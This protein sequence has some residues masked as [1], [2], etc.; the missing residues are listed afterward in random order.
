MMIE[1]LKKAGVGMFSGQLKHIEH[2]VQVCVGGE[3]KSVVDTSL[4]LTDEQ[5]EAGIDAGVYITLDDQVGE[6]TIVVPTKHYRE[7]SEKH[8]L[9][10]GD[11]AIA[12]GKMM[13]IEFKGVE[14]QSRRPYKIKNHPEQTTYVACYY[15]GPL[16]EEVVAE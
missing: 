3:I 11:V 7:Q 1:K 8:S 16:P 13:R 4:W 12:V 9:K 10:V 2:G 14:E 15:I 6:T 5:L